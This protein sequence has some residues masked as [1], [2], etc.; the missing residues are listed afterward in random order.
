MNNPFDNIEQRLIKIETLLDRLKTESNDS[1]GQDNEAIFD[2]HS[3]SLYLNLSKATLYGYTQR[4]MI[5]FSKRGKKLYFLKSE[6][7]EWVKEGRQKTI[8]EIRVEAEAYLSN[9]KKR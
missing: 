1:E 7:S 5:P 9:H 6:L 4:K 3:A 8:E 2:V